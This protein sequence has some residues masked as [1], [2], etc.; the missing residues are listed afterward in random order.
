MTP[1]IKLRE[2]EGIAILDLNGKLTLG[3]E[4]EHLR[5]NLLNLLDAGTKKVIVNFQDLS[6]ID[7]T[8]LG[9]VTFCSVKFRD[10]GGKLTLLNFPPALGTLSEFLRL[11]LLFEIHQREVD[12]VNSFFERRVRVRYDILEFVEYA[13]CGFDAA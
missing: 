1:A 13:R 11:N 2:R 7:N 10:A 3:L 6:A 8:G 12:A 9:T 4:N 5:E